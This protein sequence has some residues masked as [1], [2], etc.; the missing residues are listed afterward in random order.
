VQRELL[1][2][3]EVW[4]DLEAVQAAVDA[5]RSEYNTSRPHQSLGMAFPADRFTP[6][7]TDAQLPLRSPATLTAVSVPAPRP[8]PPVENQSAAQQTLAAPLVLSANGIDAVNLAVEVTRVVPA[9]E[10]LTVCGQQ[11][12]LRPD[13][14]GSPV[15][16]WA[17]TTVV[18]LIHNGVRLKLSRPGSPSR[19][20]S[21]CWPRTA[22]RPGRHPSRP[23][24]AAARSR[25]TGSSTPPAWSR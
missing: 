9:S 3:V 10:D 16:L 23:A 5:F 19:S 1:D 24:N 4:P 14:A 7:P 17:D 13:P 6:R 20:C 11:F 22:T 15:T 12:W 2:D 8:A 25:L 21:S 18:H